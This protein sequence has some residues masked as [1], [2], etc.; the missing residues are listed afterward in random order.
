MDTKFNDI[1]TRY[2]F[3]NSP[4][5]E[6]IQRFASFPIATSFDN[7]EPR[8]LLIGID[9]LGATTVAFDSYKKKTE[10]ENQNTQIW[11]AKLS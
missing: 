1:E 9:V 7:R 4:L 11:K 10:Q 6:S 8:L 5:K 2:R 3:D